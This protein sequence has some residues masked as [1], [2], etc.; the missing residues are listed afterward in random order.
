MD[1]Y[2]VKALEDSY[3]RII[4]VGFC[5][6]PYEDLSD[7]IVDEPIVFGTTKDERI[8]TFE[9]VKQLFESQFEQMQGMKPSLESNRIA[10]HISPDGNSAFISEENTLTLESPDEVNSIF[11]RI[12]CVMDYIDNGWK[13]THWHASTPVDTENDHWHLEEWK[14]EKERLQQLV[15]QQTADLQLKNR[16]L[17]IEAAIERVRAVAMGMTQPDDMLDVC[18]V[19]SDQL[20]QFGVDRIRNVQTAII[21]EEIGRYLCYQYFTPYDETTIESTEYH[22]SPVEHEMVK[23]MLASRNEQFIGTLAG[24]DLDTFRTHRKDENQFPDPL[25]DETSSLDYCFLSI[26]EGGLGLSLYE[27]FS[28]DVLTLFS[29]FHQVFSLAYRRFRDIEKAEE[30]ARESDIQL[31]LERVRAESLAM[32]KTSELKQVIDTVFSQLN[33]LGL[34]I[35]ACYIDIFEPDNW[36]FHLWVGTGTETYPEQITVPYI[37]HP[38]FIES[39]KARLQ[40]ESFFTLRIDKKTKD[41][42]VK[43]TTSSINVSEERAEFMRESDWMDMSVSLS[44]HAALSVYN[45]RG[46]PYSAEENDIIKRFSAVFQQA[47]TRFLDLKKAEAQ[48]KEAKI[49]L[50]LE[51]VRAKTMAMKT[52]SDLLDIIELFGQ[53]LNA[54]DI[55]F[56]NV[57]FIEGAI[58]KTRDWDLWSHAPDAEVPTQKILIPYIEDPHFKKTAEAVE[59]YERTGQIVHVKVFTKSEKDSF[60]PH[61]VKHIPEHVTEDFIEILYDAPGEI[62]VDAF[63]EEITVSLVKWD[64]EPYSEDELAIFERFAKEFRQTYIRYLDIKKAEAQARES[65]IQLALERVRART[66]AMHN[67]NELG[68]VASVLFEQIS[69]LTSAPDRFNI[70]IVNE[71]DESFDIFITDQKGYQI[72]NKFKADTK[73]SPVLAQMFEGWKNEAPY[74][75]QDIH[76]KEL[77][78]WIQYIG[79]ILGVPFNMEKVKEHRFL[80]SVFFSHGFIGITTHEKPDSETIQLLERFSKVFQQTYVR[81]LDLKKAEAQA[82]EAEIQL[83]LERV[84]AKAMAMHDSD[85]VGDATSILFEELQRLGIE[86][87]RCGVGIFKNEH[88]MEVWSAVSSKDGGMSLTMGELD[89]NIHP[90]LAGAYHSWKAGES[91]YSYALKG[92]DLESY[93]QV[94]YNQPEYKLPQQDISNIKQTFQCTWYPEGGLYAFTEDPLDKKS[95]EIFERFGKVFRLTYRRFL[96]LKEAEAKALEA[97]IEAALERIRSRAM[98]MQKANE[99]IKVIKQ[100][101]KEIIELGINV[102]VS[103]IFTDYTEDPKTGINVWFEDSAIEEV[104]YL[105]KLHVPY[106]DDPITENLYDAINKTSDVLLETYSKS[107]KNSYFKLLFKES[108]LEKITTEERQEFVLNAPGWVR[109]TVILKNS[110]LNFARYSLHEFNQKEIAVFRRVGKV[111]EQAYT[112]FLDIQQAEKLALETARQA[113]LDR[114]RAEIGSMRSSDDLQQITPIIWDELNK[115]EIPFTRCGVFIIDEENELSKTYLSTSQG[116]PIA[117]MH[118]PLEG[119]PLVKSAV[120]S[121]KQKKIYTEHWDEEDFRDWTQKLI[122]RGFIDSKKK[123]EAGSAPVTLD[124]HFLPFKHGMLYIGNT[125][126]LSREHLDLGQ[127]L[128]SAFSVAYDRYEDFVK[129]EK[130]KAGIEDALAE[131]KATQTQLV[132]Q[133][134][135]AS[136]GQLTA[137][138]AH[139]IKN[140]LNFVNNFSDVSLELVEEIR[141]EIRDMRRETDSEKATGKSE[142]AENPLSRG[143]GVA[144]GNTRG[145]LEEAESRE[146]NSELVLEILDDIETNLKTIHKHGSRADSIVKSMLQ[147]SRGGD[148][149]MEP[150]LLNPII[151]EYVNLAFHGMRAGKDPINVDIDLQLDESVG[152][153]PLI[154][155]DFSRVILNLVNN[156]FDAMREKAKVKSEKGEEYNPKLSIQ[157]CQKQNTVTIEIEDNGPGIPDEIKDKILQPFFTTKK[158]TA[159]TGLGLSITNDIIKAHGGSLDIKSSTNKGTTFSILLT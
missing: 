13:L 35:D 80:S 119:I 142:K 42:L 143:D 107:E 118:L 154:A 113:S 2:K 63:F 79:D 128:A 149:K 76:G 91:R 84:R 64:D 70:A 10:T 11:M 37:D 136:L 116:D 106:L 123:Y 97:Q 31:A 132:Q 65:Q 59:D 33:Q 53:Q 45:Y 146:L 147:H 120:S 104:T 121:W 5:M 96:D 15:D 75:I 112:R 27:P 103:N 81:F 16:E 140:P 93:Y 43:H 92:K 47:Y 139:E 24:E 155:E 95:F 62:I 100:I 9:G 21:D 148:G 55:K 18:R 101:D 129:L 157:T 108:D 50:A 159:G 22:K 83:A 48:A 130:A 126:P 71:A 158:G 150:T 39:R 145:V 73:R 127:S 153:V 25:L 4:N 56:N 152:E 85:D 87:I 60:V 137:G 61:F 131:L 98:G 122:D 125:E 111:F 44:K 86:T 105:E 156:A 102:D 77:E 54:V 32:H 6:V 133:E 67:S 49:Q 38:F 19:I 34:P 151:K 110:S 138:I 68:E 30:Q 72:E 1:S 117:A 41:Q 36:D 52:Q 134:K 78:N 14:R 57:T 82:R 3:Q 69:L 144:D 23:K 12:S 90:V 141:N 26:G 51:R 29:R 114:I 74:L 115:L 40:G 58:T 135:L 7:I 109:C 66:M 28:Q 8:F 17:E 94:I 20:Q 99:L 46:K 89:L 124:L 88:D